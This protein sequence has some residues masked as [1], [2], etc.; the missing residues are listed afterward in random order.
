MIR[1]I[2]AAWRAYRE[3]P[4]REQI[5]LAALLAGVGVMAG[6]TGAV[7]LIELTSTPTFCR[8]CHIMRPY[9]ETWKRS[10]H[11]GIACIQCHIPPGLE[12]EIHKKI[13]ALNM[14][15]GYLTQTWGDN[16]WA[17]VEDGACLR[18]H[19]KARLSGDK[20]FRGVR[21][22]HT[23]HLLYEESGLKLRCTSC[24]AQ[25]FR[26][27]HVWVEPR[28][29]F[30]CHLRDDAPSAMKA[31][32]T[33][34]VPPDT[35][36][37]QTTVQFDHGQVRQ[38]GMTCQWCHG[39]GGEGK[40]EAQAFRCISCHNRSEVLETVGEVSRLH[41]IHTQTTKVDCIACHTPVEHTPGK[42]L[43]RHG[44]P[45]ERGE[46]VE[47]WCA[48]CHGMRHGE[49]PLLYAGE[50]P[51]QNLPSGHPDPMA[52]VGVA[53][54][55]CHTLEARVR[56]LS[57]MACHGARFVRVLENWE[58]ALQE[59]QRRVRLALTRRKDKTL[60]RVPFWMVSGKAGLH[61]I[62]LTLQAAHRV[63][64]RLRQGTNLPRWEVFPG[65]RDDPCGACHV[66][67][68]REVRTSRW[69][70]PFHHGRH[71]QPSRDLRCTDCHR[72]HEEKPE[73][74]ILRPGLSCKTCHHTRF[75]AATQCRTCHPR[76]P[77]EIL[78]GKGLSFPHTYHYDPD[79]AER[80]CQDCHD[81]FSGEVRWEMCLE[82][83]EP[84]EL[85]G[86][87]A[88]RIRTG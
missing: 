31:C 68:A 69:V 29:C 41:E 20:L 74:E 35:V 33:C 40:G 13:E 1:G 50:M 25:I 28:V 84:D 65:E 24:H 47:E 51:G 63:Y 21:F 70:R 39:T 30:L 19:S 46:M 15:V 22:N 81:V 44:T 4:V 53:C 52:Q 80:L 77:E 85:P 16:P 54:E 86:T 3:R 6:I 83:H 67:V 14:V 43:T 5:A 45:P 75:Q 71:I 87:R 37:Q 66:Q 73:G 56:G 62:R 55:T 2:R 17:V 48:S 9:Y 11:N 10:A 60:P 18:C 72:T 36:F 38:N 23:P 58:E 79:G 59:A 64:E 88:A 76:L 78:V 8:S 42:A 82:C 12:M 61:N 49:I 34:H 57:C 27:E 26:D 7:G 32:Q